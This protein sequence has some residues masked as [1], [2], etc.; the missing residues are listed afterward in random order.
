MISA[1]LQMAQLGELL[2]FHSVMAF[3][4][5]NNLV[6]HLESA[7][8]DQFKAYD[9]LLCDSDAMRFG[10][11]DTDMSREGSPNVCPQSISRNIKFVMCYVCR[12]WDII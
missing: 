8:V 2:A 3:Q 11:K 9:M 7:S 10:L 1:R 5:C 4:I 6:P 12:A